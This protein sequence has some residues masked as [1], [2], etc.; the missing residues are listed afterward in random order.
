MKLKPIWAKPETHRKF[1]LKAAME[2]LKITDYM[3]K[4]ANQELPS[5]EIEKKKNNKKKSIWENIRV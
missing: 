1:K 4:L 3:A 2:G 5:I